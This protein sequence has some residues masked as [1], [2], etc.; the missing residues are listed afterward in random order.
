MKLPLTWLLDYV[1]LAGLTP[2]AIAYQLTFGGMEVEDLEYVGLSP[3]DKDIAGY[4]AQPGKHKGLAWNPEKIVTAQILEVMPHPNAD[5]LTLLRLDDGSGK[6]QIVLTGAPNIFHLK[7]TGPLPT[8]IKVVYAREGTILYDGHKPGQALMTLKKTKIRGVESYSMVCSEKELG[9]SEEHDG[10][11]ILDDDAP[12]GVP[13]AQYMGDVVFTIKTNPNMAR[14]INVLG[15]AR[16]LAALTGRPLRQ[17]DYTVQATGPSIQGQIHLQITN[18]DLNPRFTAALIKG[19]TPAPSRYQVQRRLRL[20]GVRPIS[21]IVDAT[22]YVMIEIGQPLHAFDY[23]VLVARAKGPPTIITRLPTPGEVL[24]TLDGVKRKLDE[25]N[26]LVCDTAGV[27]SLGGIMGG[28]ESEVNANTNN[29]LLEGAAWEF[30]NIRKTSR[31]HDLLSEAAYR[32]SRGIHPAM[33]ARGVSRAIE[34]MRQWA[35][36]EIAQGLVDEYPKPAPVVTLDLAPQDVAR[37]LGVTLSAQDIAQ[38][39]ESLEFK[40]EIK[41]A[42]GPNNQSPI[43]VVVPDHRLDIGTGVIGKADLIEEIA[44][45]Y[46]FDRI[47]EQQLAD[48]LPAQRPNAALERE[49]RVRDILVGA[50][51]QEIITYS[52]TTPASERRLL[53]AN[54]PADERPYVTLLNPIVVERVA[55][56]HTLLA[57]VLDVVSQNLRH[58]ERIAV[59]EIG[60]VYLR[61]E[62]GAEGPPP[63]PNE[64]R[65]LTIAL[66]GPRAP[67]NWQGA[68]LAPMDFFDLK[69][70]V[71]AL[72]DSLHLSAVAYEAA[73]HP[74]FLPGRTARLTVGEKFI[75]WL[76]EL[77]PLVRKAFD[78]DQPILA[79]DLDLEQLLTLTNE[80]HPVRGVPEYPPV[81]EDLAVIVDEAIP[82]AKVQSVIQAAGGN[83]LAELTLFDVYRGPQIGA[84][85]KS[86]AYG[87]TYLAPDKTLT[88]PDSAK[89]R[90]KIVKKLQDELGAVLR[91]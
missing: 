23:D 68:D 8:P 40:C 37:L 44:R 18:S 33:T 63:L 84:G 26:I 19:V 56:R 55:L 30:I 86:L 41:A 22:N 67:H 57:G 45:I 10:I 35:G 61:D 70:V 2:E 89:L 43:T 79:A 38:I 20:A 31:A 9:I 72:T 69:G 11:I 3:T 32:F 47:P 49:E 74:T 91:S 62:E 46:G 83:L 54:I 71:E 15:V 73:Q 77:H 27:L 5:R 36:G 64:P 53:P 81:K 16:E 52:L 90:A 21:N 12:V 78:V 88:A 7:G 82:A 14:N 42:S 28:A 59:F 48:E 80:R 4:K 24:K 17:P 29:V 65:R 13:L 1:D 39:L 85:K 51:L 76:G 34:L 50:G 87:L 60:A 25:N 66:T 58:H 75:G 6:E